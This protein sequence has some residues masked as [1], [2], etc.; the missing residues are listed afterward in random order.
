[1]SSRIRGGTLT[2][3]EVDNEL[4]KIEQLR[5]DM[6]LRKEL[7]VETIQALIRRQLLLAP[8]YRSEPAVLRPAVFPA[9]LLQEA[10]TLQQA[11]VNSIQIMIWAVKACDGSYNDSTAK[12]SAYQVRRQTSLCM[13]PSASP[14]ARMPRPAAARWS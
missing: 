1:V 14:S 8:F 4:Q 13:T 2:P 5:T 9:A 3:M 11:A 7:E 12:S 10:V 6:A